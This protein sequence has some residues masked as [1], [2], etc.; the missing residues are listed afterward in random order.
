MLQGMRAR[1]GGSESRIS[2]FTV[3]VI[4]S[5]RQFIFLQQDNVKSLEIEVFKGELGP[6]DV[7]LG[8][9]RL[10]VC[11]GHCPAASNGGIQRRKFEEGSAHLRDDS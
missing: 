8:E 3:E 1:E 4:S 10:V 9:Q 11:D 6:R 7:E 2:V 5:P